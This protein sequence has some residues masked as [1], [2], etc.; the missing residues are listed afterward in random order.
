MV[1]LGGAFVVPLLVLLAC[2][3][4]AYAQTAAP[5]APAPS[6][7]LSVDQIRVF[8]KNAKVIGNRGT[9]TGVTAPRRLT[10]TD[11]SITQT[12]LFQ[13][14]TSADNRQSRGGARQR[15]SISTSLI[16]TS[17]TCRV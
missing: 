15:R 2:P 9:P 6:A 14:T 5:A 11:G 3:P 1:R 17:T 12:P 8:L 7:E 10:L 16:L 13:A 4:L